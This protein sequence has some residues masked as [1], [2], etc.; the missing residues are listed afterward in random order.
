[1]CTQFSFVFCIPLLKFLVFSFLIVFFFYLIKRKFSSCFLII[2]TSSHL[3]L[4]SVDIIF[5]SEW[6]IF[7]TCMP[8]DF[9][10]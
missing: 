9:M 3:A 4:A 2:S 6:V 8:I 5:P 1:M 10:L 7:F